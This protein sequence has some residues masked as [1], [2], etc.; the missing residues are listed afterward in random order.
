MTVEE[1]IRYQTGVEFDKFKRD[2]ERGLGRWMQRA[3]EVRRIIEAL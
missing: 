1:W 2:G 3:Q